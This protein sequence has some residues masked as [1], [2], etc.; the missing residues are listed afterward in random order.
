MVFNLKYCWIEYNSLTNSISL[1]RHFVNSNVHHMEEMQMLIRCLFISAKLQ[2]V[3][4]DMVSRDVK[5][6]NRY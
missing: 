3:E 4:M 6:V 2:D 1:R 5:S